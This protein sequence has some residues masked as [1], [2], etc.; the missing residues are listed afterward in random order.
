MTCVN[1]MGLRGLLLA[2][3]AC[4]QPGARLAVATL[5]PECRFVV[6]V[7]GFTSFIDCHET[8]EAALAGFV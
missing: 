1:S 4:K 2:A 6:E 7:S 8:C 5:R 3:K